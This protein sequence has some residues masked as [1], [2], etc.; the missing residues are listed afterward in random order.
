VVVEEM[1]RVIAWNVMRIGNLGRMGV[2][3]T[4]ALLYSYLHLLFLYPR[5]RRSPYSVPQSRAAALDLK[6]A[7]IVTGVWFFLSSLLLFLIFPFLLCSWDCAFCLLISEKKASLLPH[8]LPVLD[9]K[10]L[11]VCVVGKSR[12]LLGLVRLQP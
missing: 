7:S 12:H 10:A 11:W 1:A 3:W 4:L 6:P 8:S 5:L 9:Q 2:L